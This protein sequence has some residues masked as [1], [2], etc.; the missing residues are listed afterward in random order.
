MQI[1]KTKG[2]FFV[3]LSTNGGKSWTITRGPFHDKIRAKLNMANSKYQDK[4][5]LGDSPDRLWRVSEYRR[6]DEPTEPT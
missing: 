3:E 6:I 1:T 2:I 4:I 5:D